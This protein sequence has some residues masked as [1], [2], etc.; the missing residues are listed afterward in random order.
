ME[1]AHRADILRD[2]Q[3][4]LNERGIS[5]ASLVIATLQDPESSMANDLITRIKDVL[6]ALCPRLDSRSVTELGRSFASVA[7]SELSALG[8]DDLWHLPASK[9]SAEQLQGFS[10]KKMSHQIASVAPGLSSFLHAICVGKNA[11]VARHSTT[12]DD[13]ASIE[14]GRLLE[15]VCTHFL[16]IYLSN[17]DA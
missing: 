2:V 17:A 11:N 8:E 12:D 1:H 15:I 16:C 3:N 7:S 14:P 5:L 10:M 9:L 6:E 13:E 4:F